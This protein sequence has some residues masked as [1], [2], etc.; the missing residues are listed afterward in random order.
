ML[1][2]LLALFIFLILSEYFFIVFDYIFV[3]QVYLSCSFYSFCV[4]LLIYFVCYICFVCLFE[5]GKKNI[6]IQMKTSNAVCAK[7]E[8]RL[9]ESTPKIPARPIRAP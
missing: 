4:Y 8:A 1:F 7:P 2:V 3:L 9:K 5:I 6:N